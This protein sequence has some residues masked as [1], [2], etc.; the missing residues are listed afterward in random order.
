MQNLQFKTFL[1]HATVNCVTQHLKD[2]K[3]F[4][5]RTDLL[6]VH[7]CTCYTSKRLLFKSGSHY[8]TN[9]FEI[10]YFHIT[11]IYLNTCYNSE[12]RCGDTMT[13][14]PSCIWRSI[15]NITSPLHKMLTQTV[16][17]PSSHTITSSSSF[18]TLS[19]V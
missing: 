8:Y 13:G 15:V 6:T 7:T 5:K 3:A 18:T 2:L 9:C 17:L 10:L 16:S 4:D 12:R 11:C 14:G 1:R 19:P